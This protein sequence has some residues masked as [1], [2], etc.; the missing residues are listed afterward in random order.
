M[1]PAK[2][3]NRPRHAHE[4]TETNLSA[5]LQRGAGRASSLI[6]QKAARMRGEGAAMSVSRTDRP[7][8][9]KRR[10]LRPSQ[11][12]RPSTISKRGF[13][14]EP[15]IAPPFS[16]PD[17]DQPAVLPVDHLARAVHFPPRGKAAAARPGGR[18]RQMPHAADATSN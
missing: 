1:G 5:A 8:F 2:S 13:H 9:E 10:F 17:I 14:F 3:T 16:G 12:T 18:R 7:I 11:G 4:E 6:A 15:G